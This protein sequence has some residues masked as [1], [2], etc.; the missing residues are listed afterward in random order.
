MDECGR[1]VYSLTCSRCGNKHFKGFSRCKDRF[2][3]I[4]SRL[5]TL[6]YLKRI[7]YVFDKDVH[8]M[9]FMT[10]TLRNYDD[11]EK[12]IQD[13]KLYWRRFYNSDKGFRRRFKERFLGTIKSM[14]VK[15][16]MDRKWHVHLHM[17][18]ITNKEYSKDYS[19]LKERWKYVTNGNGSVYI[20]KVD[21]EIK[22]IIET[23][24]YITNVE[25][26]EESDLI[27]IYK[28]IKG[29][30]MVSSTGILFGIEDK[31]EEDVEKDDSIEEDIDFICKKCGYDKYKL[32][33]LV[34][35]DSLDM[36]DL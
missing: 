33:V 3:I 12:M 2:C 23:F 19:W 27:Y 32:E 30:R 26:I 9:H 29:K 4:C 13:I 14:E 24:K 7:L 16:G 20:E 21:N 18:M 28:V 34:F 25:K 22:G 31:V 6:K 1:Y 5:R 36:S 11:L 8:N 17:L 10:L 35:N 15:K